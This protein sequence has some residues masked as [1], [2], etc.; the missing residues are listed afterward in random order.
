MKTQIIPAGTPGIFRP[1]W[2]Q[3]P[4]LSARIIAWQ[5]GGTSYCTSGVAAYPTLDFVDSLNPRME[6]PSRVCAWQY[7]PPVPPVDGLH[8][9]IFFQL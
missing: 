1:E 9:R 5:P 3:F 7:A 4:E 8:T 2:G 6:I